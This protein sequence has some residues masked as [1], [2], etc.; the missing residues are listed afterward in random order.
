MVS[1][2]AVRCDWAWQGSW[3]EFVFGAVRC[4]HVWI[5]KLWIGS[6][7]EISFV[8]FGSV[9]AWQGRNGEVR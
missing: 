8:T 7:G 2:V 9:A 4:G 1:S 5:G 6:C 3:G